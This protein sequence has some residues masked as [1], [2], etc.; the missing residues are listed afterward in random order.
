MATSSKMS[1]LRSMK[2][3]LWQATRSCRSCRRSYQG[4]GRRGG[5]PRH[6]A[7]RPHHRHVS[8]APE[9]SATH[10][11]QSDPAWRTDAQTEANIIKLPNISASVPQLKE[12]IKELQG[13]GYNL[14]DYPE[15]PQ[16]EEEKEINAR[17]SK[18][19]G[20]AV[21]PVLRDPLISCTSIGSLPIHQYAL[22]Q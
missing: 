16:T 13:K 11:R 19:L 1:G 6:F 21:N 9:R 7:R 12:A 3:P 8:G 5:N 2:R 22:L 20:S 10:R 15:N 18:V 17:Y 14:P 4:N